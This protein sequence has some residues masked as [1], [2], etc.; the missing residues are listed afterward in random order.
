MKKTNKKLLSIILAM[1]MV[2]TTIPTFAITAFAARTNCNETD[3][4][5]LIM[6]DDGSI[7]SM[8]LEYDWNSGNPGTQ[9]FA[10][11]DDHSESDFANYLS[12]KGYLDA[13][14]WYFYGGGEFDDDGDEATTL[15]KGADGFVQKYNNIV[16][17]K[18]IQCYYYTENGIETVL[19]NKNIYVAT[20]N[21]NK[22]ALKKSES[23]KSY[24]IV[25][26]IYD[27][28][29]KRYRPTDPIGIITIKSDGTIYYRTEGKN[30]SHQVKPVDVHSG[31]I[32]NGTPATY[33]KAGFKDYYI[34]SCGKVFEDA[35]CN[36]EITNLSAWKTIG[37]NGYIP[38][39]SHS[40][41]S[42][43]STQLT[44][45]I[46][47]I[48]HKN[49]KDAKI[50]WGKVAD[51]D[52]YIIYANYCGSKEKAIKTVTNNK[53]TSYSFKKLGGKALDLTKPIKVYV[54]AYKNVNGKKVQM[55][56]SL[57][58][59]HSGV[60]NKKYTVVKTVKLN[61][62][63]VTIT[64]GK[65]FA[66]KATVN[67]ASAKKALQT[68]GHSKYYRYISSNPSVATVN[69]N[70][71]ITAKKAG[72]CTIYV[73]T[74]N[75]SKA[76]LAV[77]VKESTTTSEIFKDGAQVQLGFYNVYSKV[78]IEPSFVFKDNKYEF[79]KYVFNGTDIPLDQVVSSGLKAE[80]KGDVFSFC[81]GQYPDAKGNLQDCYLII[82]T[83]AKTYKFDMDKNDVYVTHI[84]VNGKDI[85]KDMKSITG[86][87][88]QLPFKQE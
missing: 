49:A 35:N 9:Y 36:N 39:T 76:K 72:K 17:D 62:N 31:V 60:N 54:A 19:K 78:N 71:V 79:T 87:N 53:T 26:F 28:W 50:S 66:V 56:K 24:R 30:D 22:G 2:I 44:A 68:E 5:N 86:K 65:T 38:P 69:A 81:F 32:Q 6:Y 52:G 58:V 80:K 27:S 18:N 20:L 75:G 34:C 37:G 7:K 85:A 40:Y 3:I 13:C 61:K 1:L 57:V 55:G 11:F 8:D 59:H 15:K 70:G 4:S 21:F 51:A 77:T 67:K 82:D 25:L 74:Q 63:A 46:R 84:L 14:Y 43:V 45:G 64:Q 12:N 41:T 29:N 10:F 48:E 23:D 42:K 47:L 16:A 33:T 73:V 83:K 88:L